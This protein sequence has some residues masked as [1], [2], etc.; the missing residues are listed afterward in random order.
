MALGADAMPPFRGEGGCH[1]MQ[2]AL[3]L[4]R[5][6]E[7]MD[8]ADRASV[9]EGLGAY[10]EEMLAR[11]AKAT[12]LSATQFEQDMDANSRVVAGRPLEVL[13]QETITI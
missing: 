13:P 5:A 4:A 12:R 1:A 3:N 6:V 10:Q 8:K 7:T 2:D 9:V 11:G